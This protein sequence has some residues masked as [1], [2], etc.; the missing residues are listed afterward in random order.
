MGWGSGVSH[1]GR[2]IGYSVDAECDKPGCTEKIDRGLAF[3]CGDLS[4]VLHGS[5]YGCGKYFCH[6]HLFFA[7]LGGEPKIRGV[8]LCEDCGEEYG[9]LV[10][11]EFQ[12]LCGRKGKRADC[13]VCGDEVEKITQPEVDI[14][15]DLMT[16][17]PLLDVITT[18]PRDGYVLKPCMHK[19]ET[20]RW[21]E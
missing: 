1:D 17:I 12:M 21:P 14:D 7:D 15:L 2:K 20:V 9:T 16:M 11:E 4:E 10:I 13:P 3:L 8:S 19:V 5:G 6:S 18:D